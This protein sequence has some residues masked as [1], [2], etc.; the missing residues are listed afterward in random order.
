MCVEGHREVSE[1]GTTVIFT[2]AV[3]SVLG[4][5]DGGPRE[6]VPGPPCALTWDRSWRKEIQGLSVGQT[7]T[8][9]GQEDAE[10]PEEAADKQ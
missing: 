9:N 1:A 6:I 7:P 4:V 3:S 5:P 8:W 10:E 2:S